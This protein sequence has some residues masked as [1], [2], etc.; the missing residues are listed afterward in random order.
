MTTPLSIKKPRK[1]PV[2]V[3]LAGI[4]TVAEAAELHRKLG[5][6]IPPGSAWTLAAAQLEIADLAIWQVLHRCAT[7][8]ESFALTTATPCLDRLSDE[9]GLPLPTEWAPSATTLLETNS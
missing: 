6:K 4:W 8:A 9:L 1:G 5:E 7:Q 2:E 3:H